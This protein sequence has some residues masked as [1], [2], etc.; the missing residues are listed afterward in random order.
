V[1]GFCFGPIWPAAMAIATRGTAA[2]S[3]A[4]VVTV[5]N[6]G[7]VLLPWLQGRVLVGAG[8]RAGMAVS[9]ALCAGMLLIAWVALRLRSGQRADA[10]QLTG[11]GRGQSRPT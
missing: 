11:S 4:V 6:A 9:A 3:A 8:P 7:G 5:G 2:N 10:G 1:T